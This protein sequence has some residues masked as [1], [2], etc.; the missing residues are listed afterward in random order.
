MPRVEPRGGLVEEPALGLLRER[1]REE[2]AAALSAR[3]RRRVPLREVADVAGAHRLRARAAIL[4]ASPRRSRARAARGPAA[5]GR[6][7]RIGKTRSTLCGTYAMRRAVSR[8]G[9]DD[10][11]PAVEESVSAGGGSTRARTFRRVDLP[12]PFSPRTATISPPR[13]R[14]V[15]PAQRGARSVRRRRARA[16]RR[17]GL[18]RSRRA[19]EEPREERRADGRRDRADREL[20]GREQRRARPRRRRRAAPRPRWRRAAGAPAGRCPTTA[21]AACGTRRPTKPMTPANATAAPVR[22]EAARKTSALR[23]LR[24]DAERGGVLLADGEEVQPRRG[25]RGAPRRPPSGV[26]AER[27]ARAP[28]SRRR[29]SPSSRRASSAPPRPR[30]RRTRRAAARR[31]TRSR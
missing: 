6:G 18:P 25:G 5:R 19:Q 16:P 20:G 23:A 17:E 12:E 14:R 28:G 8:R 11:R 30:R 31:R 4:R 13:D 24:V 29:G 7:S 22:S 15:E 21:R 27:R 1:A 9:I 26:R 3:E 2:D 10:E